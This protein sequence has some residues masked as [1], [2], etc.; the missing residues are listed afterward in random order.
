[1]AKVFKM[2]AK[3]KQNFE[4]VN[5]SFFKNLILVLRNIKASLESKIYNISQIIINS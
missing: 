1:M 5:N 4:L 3:I 2:D